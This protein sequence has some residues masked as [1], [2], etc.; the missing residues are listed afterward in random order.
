MPKKSPDHNIAQRETSEL[1]RSS[2]K[3]LAQLRAAMN[4]RIDTSDIPEQMKP[5]VRVKR[6]ANG[7]L[8]RRPF[9]PI[10]DAILDALELRGMTRYQLWKEAARHCG[11]LSQSAVYEYLRGE[12][13]IGIPYVEAIMRAVGLK[14]TTVSPKAFSKAWADSH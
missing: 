14:V 3:E 6:D 2:P 1:K 5:G 8:P 7:Q 10:R 13:E 4:G 12:R 11:T 9:S